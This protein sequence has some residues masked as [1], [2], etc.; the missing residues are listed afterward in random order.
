MI[1][2]IQPFHWKYIEMYFIGTI[3]WTLVWLWLCL[4]Q[5]QAITQTNVDQNHWQVVSLPG[6]NELMA[7][8]RLLH[9]SSIVFSLFASLICLHMTILWYKYIPSFC[10]KTLHIR[11]VWHIVLVTR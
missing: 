11:D 8:I 2:I 9:L 1:N 3:S 5:H 6:D 10:V 7:Y 4:W